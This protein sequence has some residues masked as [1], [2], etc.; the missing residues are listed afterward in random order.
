MIVFRMT[1][2]LCLS[3]RLSHQLPVTKVKTES[4]KVIDQPQPIIYLVRFL[5]ANRKG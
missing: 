5:Y 2:D 1:T 3:V 4:Q